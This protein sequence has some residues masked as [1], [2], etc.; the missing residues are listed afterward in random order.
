M[1]ETVKRLSKFT[2]KFKYAVNITHFG[3]NGFNYRMSF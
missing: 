2:T 3:I 1:L